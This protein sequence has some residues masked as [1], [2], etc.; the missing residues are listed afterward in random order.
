MGVKSL[1]SLAPLIAKCWKFA[2]FKLLFS[3]GLMLFSSFASGVGILMIIPLMGA[4]GVDVGAT[5]SSSGIASSITDWA[6]YFGVELN[7]T[8]VLALYLVIMLL[9]AVTSFLSSI[10]SSSL[11]NSFLIH[12]R[13]EITR[14]LFYTQWR[15][16]NQSHMSD[17]MRLLTGQVQSSTHSLNLLLMLIS[18]VIVVCVYIIFSLFIS[19]KLT[20]IALLCGLALIA[21]LW[22]INRRIHA[23][24]GKGLSANTDMHRNLFENVA[25]LKMIKSYVAEEQYLE[26]M[27]V[28]NRDLETQQTRIAKFNAMSRFVNTVGAALIFTLLFYS[29]VVW[30]DLPVSNLLV[31]L[32]I[33]SRLMPQLSSIQGMFQGLIHQAPS[34]QD[35]LDR[36]QELK[37][38]G[39][40]NTADV[41]VLPLD[42]QLVLRGVA[43]QHL[44][45]PKPTF[46]SLNVMIPSKK[47]VAIVGDSGAGKSTLV[48]LISGLVEP[49]EGLLEVDGKVINDSNR[50][51]W[52]KNVAY[53]TQDVFLFHDSVRENLNWVRQKNTSKSVKES[54]Q[55]LWAVL[56][57]ASADDFVKSLPL[58]LDTVVGDRGIKLSGGERQRL[59]LARA[60]LSEPELLILDEATSALDRNNELK[61]RDALVNMDGKLTIIIIAHNE[62]T[63]EHVTQRIFL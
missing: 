47:T 6:G 33:F 30:L 31:I 13:S 14:A 12:L 54:D 9:M 7:L 49:S 38:W 8:S 29:S 4:V 32:F 59:A 40:A 25:S 15:Y 45:Q 55:E 2:P 36:S 50:L 53:V 56:R 19:A 46:N 17:F 57:L 22:P 5:T 26:R 48:D 35:L 61:I 24:G 16:L 34:Y 41:T 11:R 23:S 10:V 51:S 39:E 18:A 27:D 58:G 37:E 21:V 62:T 63:I 52:R 20:A 43:Y 3:L 28:A 44:G 1:L 60:L 42:K